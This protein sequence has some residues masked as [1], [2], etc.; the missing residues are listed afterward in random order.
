MGVSFFGPRGLP[1]SFPLPCTL[2]FVYVH[3]VFTHPVSGARVRWG[4]SRRIHATPVRLVDPSHK[5]K[6]YWRG[7]G[8]PRSQGRAVTVLNRV[9]GTWAS[10]QQKVGSASP[11]KPLYANRPKTGGLLH[12]SNH[13]P[14]HIIFPR[15]SVRIDL[16]SQ[17][18]TSSRTA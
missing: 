4:C 15:P 3:G 14:Q 1:L 10:S 11:R 5:L 9:G 13:Q 17:A 2:A 8:C 16:A 7:Q 6:R 18:P 12:R